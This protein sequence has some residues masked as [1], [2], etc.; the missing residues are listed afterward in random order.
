MGLELGLGGVGS[1]LGSGGFVRMVRVSGWVLLYVHESLYK[2][3]STRMG[4][5]VWVC[6][7]RRCSVLLP[8]ANDVIMLKTNATAKC[9]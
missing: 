6:V 7:G 1:G 5:C 9:V 3:R 8:A 4:V 2:D